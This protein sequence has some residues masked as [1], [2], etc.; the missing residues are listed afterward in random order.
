MQPAVDGADKQGAVEGDQ[1]AIDRVAA[2]IACPLAV[3]LR[4]VLPQLLTARRVKRIHATEIAGRVQHAVDDQGRG[5]LAAGGTQFVVPGKAQPADV[6]GRDIRQRRKIRP[7]GVTAWR[8]PLLRLGAGEALD[9]DR[10]RPHRWGC[11]GGGRGGLP[12]ARRQP[13]DGKGD[14]G[15]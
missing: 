6:S 13:N 11:D 3:N 14:P 10:G 12:G 9:V 7:V 1:A 4:V 5:F 15:Q 2:G 8:E